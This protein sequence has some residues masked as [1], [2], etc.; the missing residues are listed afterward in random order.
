MANVN[1]TDES[2]EFYTCDRGCKV[3]DNAACYK[4]SFRKTHG[5]FVEGRAKAIARLKSLPIEQREEIR[6]KYGAEI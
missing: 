5:Q 4:C 1:V 3:L 2:C 6:R